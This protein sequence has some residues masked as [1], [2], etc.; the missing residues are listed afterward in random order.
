M[1]GCHYP[2]QRERKPRLLV[3]S[4]SSFKDSCTENSF[5]ECIQFSMTVSG[6][7]KAAKQ[8]SSL[9]DN[10]QKRSSLFLLHLAIW[11]PLSKV[12]RPWSHF[13][14]VSFPP[15]HRAALFGGVERSLPSPSSLFPLLQS[16]F[17][18]PA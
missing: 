5:S 12:C 10:F 14:E 3:H 4:F 13:C 7:A 1:N 18:T 16:R 17:P 11:K 2:F 15:N 6:L 8:F 9:G